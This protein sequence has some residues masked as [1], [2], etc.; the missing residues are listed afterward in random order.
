M[1]RTLTKYFGIMPRRGG[2]IS[3]LDY[4]DVRTGPLVAYR[5]PEE[6]PEYPYFYP[7]ICPQWEVVRESLETRRFKGESTEPHHLL[8]SKEHRVHRIEIELQQP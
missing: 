6:G 1:I 7:K 3:I 2:D 8:L 4:F 5:D